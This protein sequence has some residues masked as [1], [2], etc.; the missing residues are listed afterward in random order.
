MEDLT[1]EW[2]FGHPL[3]GRLYRGDWVHVCDK[4]GDPFLAADSLRQPQLRPML[5]QLVQGGVETFGTVGRTDLCYEC[6]DVADQRILKHSLM[7][8]QT[9]KLTL[10]EGCCP[11]CGGVTT[12]LCAR[13]WSTGRISC[14]RCGGEGGVEC[15]ECNGSG[16]ER[17]GTCSGTGKEGLIFKAKCSSCDGTGRWRH[18]C[19]KCEGTK[20]KETC[21]VC[22]GNRETDCF[23]CGGQGE[24]VCKAC[25]GL[26]R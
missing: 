26:G 7:E 10:R 13:C 23:V 21:E 4:C 11:A 24:Q 14:N 25:N 9:G 1:T 8:A 16:R 2:A 6:L 3:A 12:M 20:F 18:A 22:D 15:K 5:S 19:R 17:C